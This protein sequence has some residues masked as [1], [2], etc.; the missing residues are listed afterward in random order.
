MFLYVYYLEISRCWFVLCKR[1]KI[2]NA[3]WQ[4]PLWSPF[5]WTI[6]NAL[7]RWLHCWSRKCLPRQQLPCLFPRFLGTA[8]QWALRLKYRWAA[9]PAPFL[10]PTI[11]YTFGVGPDVSVE[12]ISYAV[13]VC[14]LSNIKISWQ[15]FSYY[16]K[17]KGVRDNPV[18]FFG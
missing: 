18:R 7:L 9:P 2:K 1:E 5:D 3:H 4:G 13:K 14:L 16:R 10:H 12:S 11:P 8:M 15:S 6:Q 17:R